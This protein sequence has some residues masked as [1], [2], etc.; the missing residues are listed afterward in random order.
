M[1]QSAGIVEP[2]RI[3]TD[4]RGCATRGA[5]ETAWCP[6]QDSNLRPRLRRA[7]LYPLSYGGLMCPVRHWTNLTN[8]RVSLPHGQYVTSMPRVMVVDD[9]ASIRMLIRTNL[10]LAGFEV[11]EAV[12]GQA[13]LDQLADPASLPDAITVDVM[14]PRMDG[15]TAVEAIRADP[16]TSG[17]AVVM[18][19]TQNHPADIARAADVGVDHFMVKPF[20]PEVLITELERAI[21]ARSDSST[22]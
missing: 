1:L 11:D 13:C 21:A 3:G 2:A 17:I 8:C 7:V 19:T 20:D 9:T 16:R 14:M 22:S 18:V 15:F 5:R 10:E 12:D 4:D 6:R